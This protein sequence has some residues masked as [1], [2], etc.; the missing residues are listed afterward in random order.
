MPKIT[1]WKG[2]GAKPLLQS[3]SARTIERF[4]GF[5]F[6]RPKNETKHRR[7]NKN[8]FAHKVTDKHIASCFRGLLRRVFLAIQWL[9][10]ISRFMFYALSRAPVHFT[11]DDSQVWCFAIVWTCHDSSLSYSQAW[12]VFVAMTLRNDK[13]WFAIMLS[14]CSWQISRTWQV[15]MARSHDKL[16]T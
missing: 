12:S 16:T 10:W 2:V 3:E 6:V 15:I 8:I 5:I 11:I 7:Q 14:C 1:C 13:V 9:L 4:C